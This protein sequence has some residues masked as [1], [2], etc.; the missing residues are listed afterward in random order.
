[1]QLGSWLSPC[2]SLEHGLSWHS[3]SW[4]YLLSPA[5][6]QSLP[7]FR[8]G[9]HPRWRRRTPWPQVELHGDQRSQG[10]HCRSSRKRGRSERG[11]VGGCHMARK[12][13]K[14]SKTFFITRA[15]LPVALL[16]GLLEPPVSE[17]AVVEAAQLATLLLHADTLANAGA[18]TTFLRGGN[19]Q[20]LGNRT[21]SHL[22]GKC[23]KILI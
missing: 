20:E 10:C 6:G 2:D 15:R 8:G 16:R 12:K 14:F 3:P 18:A 5:A 23:L 22:L 13:K 19:N 7:P 17:G 9:K 4:V 11:W 1:M 21:L